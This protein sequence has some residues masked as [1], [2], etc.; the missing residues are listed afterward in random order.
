[1]RLI[2]LDPRW[3]YKRKVFAFLCPHCRKT[4]L[5]CKN[6]PMDVDKQREIIEAA[7]GEYASSDIPGSKP[8]YA[9]SFSNLD[10]ATMSV[11]ASLDASP[12]GHWHGFITNG[13]IVGGI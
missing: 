1:M 11:T 12:A 10:F 3:I 13:E 8:E 7:F 5:T 9:W 2:D 6:V 4:Y